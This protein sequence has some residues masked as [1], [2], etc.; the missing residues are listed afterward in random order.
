[1][2]NFIFVTLFIFSS[3]SSLTKE[4]CDSTNWRKKGFTEGT[5][6]YPSK[7]NSY[8]KQC[9]EFG[10]IISKSEYID[11]RNEG[12]EIYCNYNNGYNLGL[13]GKMGFGDCEAINPDFTHGYSVGNT[14][15]EEQ[16]RQ[17]LQS[18]KLEDEKRIAID[19]CAHW[20]GDKCVHEIIPGCSIK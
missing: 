13:S 5:Y 2:K 17:N 4:E 11:G 19:C 3:C 7:L 15:R 20:I 14:E 6:G 9:K 10:H 12:L 8:E 18:K 16:E 1:M